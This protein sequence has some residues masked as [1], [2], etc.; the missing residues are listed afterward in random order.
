MTYGL[1]VLGTADGHLQLDCC[2]VWLAHFD[3]DAH[4]G[5]GDF[6][7][8]DKSDRALRFGSTTDAWACWRRQSSVRP[9]RPDGLPNRPLTA[10]TV[11]IVPMEQ[12]HD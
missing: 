11:Q 4:D 9:L 3:A 6:V 2:G 1:K 5:F 10:F 12:A 7:L 8:T